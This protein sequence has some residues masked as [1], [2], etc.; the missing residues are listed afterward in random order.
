MEI[1]RHH[2]NK[3][4]ID[5]GWYIGTPSDVYYLYS[6]GK[7]RMSVTAECPPGVSAF[8]PTKEDAENFLARYGKQGE[9]AMVAA[10]LHI[11]CGNCGCAEMFTW[12]LEQ[13]A[14]GWHLYIVCQNCSTVHDL[15]DNAE[16]DLGR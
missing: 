1:E 7:T 4:H 10:K 15:D 9:T 11:I 2:I 6:D 16:R 8:W 12:E 13:D 14:E 3:D 5:R